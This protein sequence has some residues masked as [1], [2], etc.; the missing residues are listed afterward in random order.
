[1]ALAV[2]EHSTM[3]RRAETLK[4]PRPRSE[5][6]TVRL[7]VEN[8]DL[9]LCGYGG[10]LV[11]KHGTRTWHGWHKLHLATNVDTGRHDGSACLPASVIHAVA[12]NDTTHP[13]SKVHAVPCPWI[14]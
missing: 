3:S 1:L 2:P 14:P 13:H 11:E 7:L 12:D 4:V 5:R 10:W 9:K 8:T 6:E